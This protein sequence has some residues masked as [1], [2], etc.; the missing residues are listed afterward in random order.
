[1]TLYESFIVYSKDVFSEHY[2]RTRVVVRTSENDIARAG[3]E[4]NIYFM[5]RTTTRG[6]C[7]SVYPDIA[8]YC[9]IETERGYVSNKEICIQSVWAGK[10]L[11]FLVPILKLYIS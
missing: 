4:G 1:M 3:P 6:P 2:C 9:T 10:T 5:V 8:L 11:N 7:E